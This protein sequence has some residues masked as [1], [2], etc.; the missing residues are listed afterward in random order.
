MKR[1]EFRAMGSR[2]LALL[3][4]TASQADETLARLPAWFEEWEQALS[5]F[6]PGNELDLLNRSAGR[7]M[8]V[9]RTL[10]E[11]FQAAC[12]A[13]KFTGG[14]VIPTVLDALVGAGYD[15]T[16]ECPAAPSDGPFFHSPGL[17]WAIRCHCLG[18]SH[19][20]PGPARIRPS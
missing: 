6:R 2:M 19:P 16:F 11:V 12:T 15:R 1:I 9:S 4:S 5:R 13:E 7:P 8:S 20:Q 3:D 18:R 10:W 17:V 14:L